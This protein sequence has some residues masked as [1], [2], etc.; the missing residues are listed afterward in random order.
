MIEIIEILGPNLPVKAL[1][2]F[3]LVD[4]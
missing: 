1:P 2:S 3:D 4:V